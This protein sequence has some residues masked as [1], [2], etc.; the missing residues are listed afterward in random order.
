MTAAFVRVAITAA[1]FAPGGS[2][3]FAHD[4]SSGKDVLQS[5]QLTRTVIIN[6]D[7]TGLEGKKMLAWR[8]EVAPAGQS[9][10]HKHPYDE[11]VY[12]L[13]GSLSMHLGDDAPVIL[14]REQSFRV[15]ANTV[16]MAS[17]QSESDVARVLVFGL[18]AK[19]E[20]LAIPVKK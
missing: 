10:W 6:S 18:T 2:F 13:D 15:P 19:D 7:L 8:A 3:A 9:A 1:I 12:V 16:H 20:P 14:Q 11:F 5:S 17:N 4:P